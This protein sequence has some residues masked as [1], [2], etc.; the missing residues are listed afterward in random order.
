MW[1]RYSCILGYLCIALCSYYSCSYRLISPLPRIRCNH[2][3]LSN[4]ADEIDQN[5]TM[6]TQKQILKEET[7]AP[8]R[9]VRI[10]F[11]ISLLAAAGLGSLISITKVLALLSQS[12]TPDND[13]YVNLG[14]N[15]GGIPVLAYLWKRDLDK[16]KGLLERIQ[17]GG[18]LA[19]LKIKLLESAGALTLKLSD[20]RRDRGID[21]RVVIVVANAE[22]VTASLQTS[23]SQSLGIIQ[24][25]LIIVPLVIDRG[26]GSDYTLIAPTLEGLVLPEG[27][28]GTLEDN[29]VH[30]GL[31]VGLAGWNNVF[32]K[33][34]STAL[35]QEPQALEK[36]ITIIIKKNG[37]V[38]TRRFGVPLW[39]SLVGDVAMRSELGLDIRNV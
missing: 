23:I 38:G 19:G 2:L 6:F 11:Y 8:F 26:N 28:N 36:G 5:E 25:D 12:R 24:N 37:K 21:K 14:I 27:Y 30:I 39:E 34:I 18:S 1:V 4:N 35:A 17:K 32:R 10:F 9:K 13:M 3:H 16:Q 22:Q 15:L 31:P 33:E 20:L 29:L 7:E